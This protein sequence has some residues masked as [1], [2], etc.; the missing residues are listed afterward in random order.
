MRATRDP[1]RPSSSSDRRVGAAWIEQNLSL[2]G[3]HPPGLLISL[4]QT[5][6]GLNKAFHPQGAT[7]PASRCPPLPLGF[8]ARRPDGFSQRG[9]LAAIMGLQFAQANTVRQ[10]QTLNHQPG[11]ADILRI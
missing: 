11:D 4:A 1:A 9:C 3:P 7:S 8:F 2:R 6:L 5:T 10:A